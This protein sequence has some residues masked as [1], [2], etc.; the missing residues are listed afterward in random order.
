MVTAL[1]GK[2]DY[3][4]GMDAART[5]LSP[6]LSTRDELKARLRV[7]SASFHFRKRLRRRRGT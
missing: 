4:E 6:S 5:T 2:K 3:L 7:A 1:I